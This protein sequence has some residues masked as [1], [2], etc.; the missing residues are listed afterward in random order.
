MNKKKLVRHNFRTSV[1]NRDNFTCKMCGEHPEDTSTLDAHHIT[2]RNEM[3]NGGYV[4]ENGI[5]LCPDCHIKAEIFHS[6]GK[7]YE[8]YSPEDLY[9]VIGST[10]DKAYAAS[11]RLNEKNK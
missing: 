9:N 8:G 2:D 5:T 1:F 4:L 11:E 10:Y 7:S 3:P 6:S